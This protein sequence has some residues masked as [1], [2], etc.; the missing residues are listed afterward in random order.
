MVVVN[1][2]ADAPRCTPLKDTEDYLYYQRVS[3]QTYAGV[4]HRPPQ[5]A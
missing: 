5:Q 2:Q 3:Y 4:Q 1:A